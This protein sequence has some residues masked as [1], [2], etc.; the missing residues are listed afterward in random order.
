[1]VSAE[2]LLLVVLAS[3]LSPM[4]VDVLVDRIALGR[5]MLEISRDYGV[6]RSRIGQVLQSSRCAVRLALGVAA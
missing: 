3:G 2:D 5:S 1:M 4:Q 6:S